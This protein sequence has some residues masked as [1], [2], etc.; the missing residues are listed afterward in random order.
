MKKEPK[1]MQSHKG[2]SSFWFE[3]DICRNI[4]GNAAIEN[5]TGFKELYTR[6]YIPSDIK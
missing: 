2:G 6:E 3:T 5:I 1:Q 4:T